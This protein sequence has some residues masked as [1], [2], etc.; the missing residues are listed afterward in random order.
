MV[1]EFNEILRTAYALLRIILIAEEGETFKRM[2][3]SQVEK[4]K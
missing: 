3:Y 1:K 2:I 4:K